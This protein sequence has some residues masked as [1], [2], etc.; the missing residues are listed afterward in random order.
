MAERRGLH[1]DDL[2]VLADQAP[3]HLFRVGD[4]RAEIEDARLQ[5]LPPAESEELS[6]Q[7]RGP[8][9]RP[10]DLAQAFAAFRIVGERRAE[11]LGVTLYDRQEI[12]EIVGDSACEAAHR[13]HLLRL[14][15]L[16]LELKPLGHVPTCRVH[17]APSADGDKPVVELDRHLAAILPPDQRLRQDLRA[18]Q[19]ALMKGAVR[20]D[21]DDGLL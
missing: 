10:N 4:D 2:D 18:S 14:A 3:Q 17:E 15:E 7:G 13:L 1:D 12:V 16:C 9:G 6:R 21:G 8:F 19:D 11:Q 20:R 5:D